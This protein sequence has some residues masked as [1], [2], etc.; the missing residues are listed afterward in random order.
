MCVISELRFRSPGFVLF[1]T[2]ERVS[3]I[4][5]DFIQEMAI[6]PEQPYLWVWA[7]G[8]LEAFEMAMDAD[9]TVAEVVKYADAGEQSLYRIHV[10]TS[11]ETVIYP[12]LVESGAVVLE[13]GYEDGWWH[14]C[15]RLPD[16][17]AL[18]EIQSW[19]EDHDVEFVL[20]GVY[21]EDENWADAPQLT[22][23]QREVLEIALEEGYFD[24]PRGGDL[25]DVAR[26]CG[27][28]TQAAS[29]R[30]RRGHRELVL[31]YL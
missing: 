4:Q 14:C 10:S 1:E 21:S 29:E 24:I 18:G 11:T 7:R 15:I 25:S 5:L 27:I 26:R 8:N 19:F 20:E 17:E 30:L 12:L 3:D 31:H 13:A 23:E 16:R 2:F 6:E 9:D 28:S 22:C